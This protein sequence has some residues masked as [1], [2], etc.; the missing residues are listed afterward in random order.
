MCY[1]TFLHTYNKKRTSSIFCYSLSIFLH[2][3]CKKKYIHF[4][5]TY[6]D[7]STRKW[8]AAYWEFTE[9]CMRVISKQNTELL[10]Q[11]M[12]CDGPHSGSVPNLQAG[13]VAKFFLIFK[14]N[15]LEKVVVQ[16]TAL[17]TRILLLYIFSTTA[18]FCT[19]ILSSHQRNKRN[20]NIK[21][22]MFQ[23]TLCSWT[24]NNGKSLGGV[25]LIC[26]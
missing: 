1:S 16:P 15:C 13:L 14:G 4:T 19:F 23:H 12:S 9:D 6:G 24:N 5:F 11:H 26:S 22:H 3:W 7:K 10:L 2:R 18:F 21:K 20:T 8:E 25:T 17:C